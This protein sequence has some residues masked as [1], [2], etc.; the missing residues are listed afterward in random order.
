MTTL[1]SFVDQPWAQSLGWTL[2]HFLW[3]GAALGLAAWLGLV[4]LRGASARARYGLACACLLLMVAAPATTALV[5][6]HQTTA[7]ALAPLSVVV[8]TAAPTAPA[9]APL[10]QR[11]KAALDPALPW[12]LAG[13]AA[14]VLL[15]STRFLGS[16]VRIQRLRRRSASHQ[17]QRLAFSFCLLAKDIFLTLQFSWRPS[18]PTNWP[19]SA[20]ATSW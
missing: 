7:Q 3:Q 4:L 14:G 16:W 13:W 1:L 2:I 5:L 6:Q 12:L 20:G 17:G 19:T 15:L 18:S 10:A 8:E 9:A 11:V